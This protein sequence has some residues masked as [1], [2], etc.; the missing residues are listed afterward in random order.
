MF[1][2]IIVFTIPIIFILWGCDG[3]SSR[4]EMTGKKNTSI[5]QRTKDLLNR[6]QYS[7][8]HVT[9]EIMQDITSIGREALPYVKKERERT[10]SEGNKYV[11][12]KII[13]ALENSV[14]LWVTFDDIPNNTEYTKAM[15]YS[16]FNLLE[17]YKE[18]YGQFPDDLNDLIE[19]NIALGIYLDPTKDT[20]LDPWGND[21]FYKRVKAREQDTLILFS[22]GPDGISKTED[23]IYLPFCNYH[24]LEK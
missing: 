3:P 1:R 23:D 9:E 24:L 14:I 17:E 19:K 10:K 15:L 12:D 21:Y 5:E 20:N 18:K 11:L 2:N 4:T 6:L 13:F 7:D 22:K 16:I 8:G